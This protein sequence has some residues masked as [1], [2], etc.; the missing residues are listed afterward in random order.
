M[1]GRIMFGDSTTTAAKLGVKDS[2]AG[3]EG[4]P[5][6]PPYKGAYVFGIVDKKQDQLMHFHWPL[7]PSWCKDY[8]KFNTSNARSED[9]HEKASYKHLL[10]KRHCII[11]VDGFYEWERTGE[12]RAFFFS[13]ADGSQ[14]K[15][16][17]LWDYN[18]NLGKPI[19][20]CTIITRE[21]NEIIGEVHDRM[22]V[23]LTED[24]MKIWLN[25]SLSYEER[26]KVLL[27]IENSAII[28]KEVRKSVN[29]AGNK[30]GDWFNDKPDD[31]L[32]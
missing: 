17:G 1:C 9:M 29:K 27:P 3:R 28:K 13:M 15:Y 31:C 2:E 25:I 30:S 18:K 21:P 24:Q 16:A 10:G 26:A 14:M 11:A 7:I 12:K 22:P 20:S 19:L 4:D 5:N 6:L 23:I 32:F 8:P